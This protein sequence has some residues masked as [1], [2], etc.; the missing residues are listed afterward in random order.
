VTNFAEVLTHEVG[1][2]I[3]LAH[4]SQNPNEPNPLLKQAIMYYMAHDNG[5]GAT[6]NQWDTNVC[7]QIHPRNTPPYNYDRLLDGV[8]SPNPLPSPEVN[9]VEV[10]G[11]DLQGGPLTLATTDATTYAGAFSVINSNFT[12]TF[13]A[14]YGDEPRLDPTTNEFYDVIYA[15]YSDG[16]NAAPYATIRLL[17]INSDS[18]SEGVPD[19][20]RTTYFGSTDPSAGPNRHA[21][22]DYDGDGYSNLAEWRLGSDPTDPA[23]NLRITSFNLTNIQWQAKPYE[24]YELYGSTNLTHWTRAMNP[25]VPTNAPASVAPATN[26]GPREF[27]RVLKVP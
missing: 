23:S 26:A 7:N 6:L 14:W 24:L 13:N 27:F 8:S 18:Y 15:R 21:T 20:W 16:T 9:T 5:R 10:R 19:W 22:D 2:T 11:Y 4:S 12:Y 1:H 3:G 17:S 25:V